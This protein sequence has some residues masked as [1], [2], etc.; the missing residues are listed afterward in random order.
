LKRRSG[1]LMILGITLVLAMIFFTVCFWG[2]WW[3]R[4]RYTV[5][6]RAIGFAL[7]QPLHVV[8]LTCSATWILKQL[9]YKGF[10]R[11]WRTYCDDTWTCR[12]VT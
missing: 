8:T 5:A 10:L 9:E 12:D 7:E 2:I 4:K 6:G 11:K 3:S 1:L